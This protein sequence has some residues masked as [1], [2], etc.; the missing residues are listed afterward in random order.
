MYS[1]QWGELLMRS[2]SERVNCLIA[3][4]HCNIKHSYILTGH[5]S[6]RKATQLKSDLQKYSQQTTCLWMWSRALP[7]WGHLEDGTIMLPPD[8]KEIQRHC[9]SGLRIIHSNEIHIKL[10]RLSNNEQECQ[11]LWQ[12]QSLQVWVHHPMGKKS[13][14][15]SINLTDIIGSQ[16]DT[17]KLGVTLS[18]NIIKPSCNEGLEDTS[19]QLYW[20]KPFT[21]MSD[22]DRISPY[23]IQQASDENSENYQLWE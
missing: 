20:L 5:V 3:R 19:Y 9:M 12:D 6:A 8:H 11:K 18:G 22:Q 7:P 15:I 1:R 13:R 10:P 21:L 23:N 17:Y 4:K 2:W 16:A 14:K